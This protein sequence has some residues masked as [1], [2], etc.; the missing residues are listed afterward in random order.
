[1]GK[2]KTGTLLLTS[3]VSELAKVDDAF[4]QFVVRSYF[5]RY[6]YCDWGEMCEE[7]KA[8]NDS[9]VENGDDRIFA[10]YVKEGL[11]KIYIITEWD[12]SATTIL[13]PDEY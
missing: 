4:A 13:F 8:M 5:Q 6:L 12:R 9:A 11:P 7:D 2:F 10:A 3:G 1:M